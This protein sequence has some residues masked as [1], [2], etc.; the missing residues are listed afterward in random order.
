[1]PDNSADHGVMNEETVRELAQ[2]MQIAL[3]DSEVTTL[4][5][6]LS[7]LVQHVSHIA[8]VDTE[9]VPMMSHPLAQS[10]VMRSDVV[11][12][13]LSLDEALQNAPDVSEGMFR[14]TSILGGEQ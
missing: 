6:E 3:S 10:N 1:M 13:V 7:V 8:E 5:D 2:T 4:T 9:D 14:V 12:D 11:A